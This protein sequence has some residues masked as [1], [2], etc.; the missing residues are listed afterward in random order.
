MILAQAAA[1]PCSLRRR[2]TTAGKPVVSIIPARF[3]RWSAAPALARFA[4]IRCVV[5]RAALRIPA[6]PHPRMTMPPKPRFGEIANY[7]S[8]VREIQRRRR[9]RGSRG[10]AYCLTF[11]GDSFGARRISDISAT[12]GFAA[13]VRAL[14]RS[15]L[16]RCIRQK[17][18]SEFVPAID[19]ARAYIRMNQAQKGIEWLEKASREQNRF[20]FFAN[21]D[22]FY[23]PLR[24]D[25]RF[26]A[27]ARSVGV[28][29]EPRVATCQPRPPRQSFPSNTGL[30]PFR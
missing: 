23:D 6:S 11:T 9:T 2:A 30:V 27:F 18:R 8:G 26:D 7:R 16:E 15:E 22:P 4:L 21:T 25:A 14:A 24:G 20:V 1:V 12:G 13:G 10:V 29:N 28:P 17:N 3:R 19:Y 5:E